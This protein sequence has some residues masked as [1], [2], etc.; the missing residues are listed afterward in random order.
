MLDPR[1]FPPW[2]VL[3]LAL[4]P[5]AGARLVP[6]IHNFL[7]TNPASVAALPAKLSQSGFYAN[8]ASASRSIADTANIVYFEVNSPLWS[9]GAAKERYISLP[10]GSAKV[11]P[12]DTSR[13]Q[14]PDKTVMAK[15]FLIDT[16]Y[17]DSN[18]RI[19]VETRFLVF[20]KANGQ[21]SGISYRWNRDQRDADLVPQDTGSNWVHDVLLG[22]RRVGK[23]WRYPSAED[24]AQCHKGRGTLGFIT[25]QLNR[26]VRGVNQLQRLTALGILASNPAQGNANLVRWYGLTETSGSLEQRVRSYFAGNCSQCHGNGQSIRNSFHNFDYF[27]PNKKI[28][29]KD[30]PGGYIGYRMAGPTLIE[31][32][33]PD[34]SFIFSKITNRGDF[35]SISP[36]QMPP[37]A[38]YQL[39]STAVGV[40]KQWIC[41]LKPGIPCTAT[42][43]QKDEEFWT[44]PQIVS[45]RRFHGSSARADGFPPSLRDG[46]LRLGNADFHVPVALYDYRGGKILLV[47]SGAREYR[48]ASRPAPG[49]YI[50]RIGSRIIKLDCL[51]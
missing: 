17:G 6:A 33:Y 36:D 12:T 50:L 18:S 19:L 40:I 15:N 42:P 47:R 32:G 14:F 31:P 5:S 7:S 23:R 35:L 26:M 13:Y 2:A 34:S 3:A 25:P 49:V 44:V 20:H 21:W 38:S 39:D 51:P 4:V 43:T 10:E 1:K 30:D 9:D 48:M 24:C 16:V 29:V 8:I 46:I 11:I 22:G 28:T 41:A 27:N 37:L 45:A